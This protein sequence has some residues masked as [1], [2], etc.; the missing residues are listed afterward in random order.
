MHD[1]NDQTNGKP[2]NP[3]NQTFKWMNQMTRDNGKIKWTNKDQFKP[4]NQIE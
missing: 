3:G 2:R 1:S 4:T